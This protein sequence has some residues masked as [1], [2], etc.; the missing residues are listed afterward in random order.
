M[1]GAQ[2]GDGTRNEAEGLEH[3]RL[4]HEV[5][6]STRKRRKMESVLGQ[7]FVSFAVFRGFL[8]PM[9]FRADG[10]VNGLIIIKGKPG[11]S[12][13]AYLLIQCNYSVPGNLHI[14][15]FT[16][17]YDSLFAKFI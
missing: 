12:F 2:E 15:Q 11:W 14:H 13:S 6:E 16:K 17:L 4:D 5:R 1:A 10:G 9:S 3:E 7:R 8:A